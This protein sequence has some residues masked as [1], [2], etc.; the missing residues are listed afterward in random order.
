MISTSGGPFGSAR[1]LHRSPQR[2]EPGRDPSVCK[3]PYVTVAAVTQVRA[4]L[5]L[6]S[7][8]LGLEGCLLFTAP[9]NEAPTLTIDAP[10]QPPYRGTPLVVS[11]RVHDDTDAPDRLTVQWVEAAQACPRDQAADPP[12]GTPHAGLQVTLVIKSFDPVCLFARA[13]DSEG[14][15]SPWRHQQFMGMNRRPRALI[16]VSPAPGPTKRIP[17]FSRVVLSPAQSIDEDGDVLAYDWTITTLAGPDLVLTD[18]AEG[19]PAQSRC[20]VPRDPAGRYRVRLVATELRPAGMKGEASDPVEQLLEI[21]EDQPACLQLTDPPLRQDLVLIRAGSSRTF[22][23]LS[24]SDDGEPYPGPGEN[25]LPNF[26]WTI[27]PLQPGQP[28][29][30]AKAGAGFEI[31]ESLFGNPR[32]GDQFNVRVEVRD[33]HFE[34]I[35]DKTATAPCAEIEPTC[36]DK[37]GCVR[38]TT[39]RVQFFP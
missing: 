17:L 7:L 4:A 27:P 31:G 19:T 33:K 9:I 35:L 22:E 11:A 13:I 1:Q 21:N 15:P 32:F 12:E 6:A 26:W 3:A 10:M 2:C 29:R 18:C 36:V 16:D 37:N 20:F 28:A 39:W 38:W 24:V 25:G 34:E 23:V 14:A 30:M 8:L 5:V